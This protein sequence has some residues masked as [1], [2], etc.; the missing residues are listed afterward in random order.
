MTERQGFELGRRLVLLG[1]RATYQVELH[2]GGDSVVCPVASSD[3]AGEAQLAKVAL[4]AHGARK[5]HHELEALRALG[6]RRCLGL[7]WVIDAGSWDGL[8]WF[9]M[10]RLGHETLQSRLRDGRAA[11][12]DSLRVMRDVAAT[13][14]FVHERGWVHGDVSP[15]NIVLSSER[16]HLIDFGEASRTCE[17][18]VSPTDGRGATWGYVA[19][20]R[21][22]CMAWDLRSDVYALGCVFFEMVAGRPVFEGN[23]ADALARQHMQRP[24]PDI[25]SFCPEFP[26][27]LL[28]LLA[29]MLQKDP[30]HRLSD[31]QLLVQAL[32][33]VLGDP[34]PCATVPVICSSRLWGRSVVWDELT[35]W[36]E[37]TLRL[38]SGAALLVGAEGIGRTRL[39]HEV[40]L[41]IRRRG[42]PVRSGWETTGDEPT[43]ARGPAPVL[44]FDDVV[45]QQSWEQICAERLARGNVV[46]VGTRLGDPSREQRVRQTDATRRIFWLGALGREAS[47]RVVRDMTA[48]L[49]SEELVERLARWS[50]GRPRE[51]QRRLEE[52]SASRALVRQASGAW[53]FASDS[54]RTEAATVPPSSELHA[55]LLLL[56]R[57]AHHARRREPVEALRKLE[58]AYELA[59]VSGDARGRKLAVRLGASLLAWHSRAADHRSVFRVGAE[60][61][62]QMVPADALLEAQVRRRI[63]L[64]H[65]ITGEHRAS[66]EE[67]DTALQRLELTQR[68]GRAFDRE[69]ARNRLD[70]SWTLYA[71]H[72]ADGAY[73][74]VQAAVPFLR[75]A[76]VPELR[77]AVHIQLANAWARK[78]RFAYT[79]RAVAHNRRALA[80]LER[81]SSSPELLASAR[82]ELGFMLLL[83]KPEHCTEAIRVLSQAALEQ[84]LESGGVLSLRIATYLTIAYR[85]A[86]MHD[87]AARQ[88]SMT[89]EY[90]L[91][92]GQRGYVGALQACAG[93]L[94]LHRGDLEEAR[95]LCLQA[96]ELWSR[97]RKTD[98]ERKSEFPFQWLALVPLLSILEAEGRAHE[99]RRFVLELTHPTQAALAPPVAELLREGREAPD[100]WSAEAWQDWSR[101]FTVEAAR[102]RYL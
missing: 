80:L 5:V 8:P 63:A 14:R 50:L 6:E 18:S 24:V 38:G 67:L 78:R 47:R 102:A 52:L 10:P 40:A 49:V 97:K 79:E 87:E 22:R 59:R 64:S 89:L 91:D 72:E 77:A 57:A 68:T 61:L 13:L 56:R 65:R 34:T 81:K 4:N 44:L 83:G 45:D 76:A 37:E 36:L 101:R 74:T 11:L 100:A 85:R 29:A 51:L 31:L 75:R 53:T 48:G 42:H 23:D 93:W 27:E 7:P 96:L 21:L 70:A 43:D 15:P 73:R 35:A 33:R 12:V 41:W 2:H 71:D 98:V 26:S 86:R 9:V 95:Y 69:R 82:F 1:S 62:E 28:P 32:G 54:T 25:T 39:L 30:F 90:A 17:L 60:L 20:E 88:G 16:A 94:A 58:A 84:P 99:S 55:E 3:P 66:L 19:P 92:C 46:I